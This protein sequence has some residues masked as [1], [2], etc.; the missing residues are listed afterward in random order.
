MKTITLTPQVAANTMHVYGFSTEQVFN[1][2][3][4]SGAF[5]WGTAT[6]LDSATGTSVLPTYAGSNAYLTAQAAP[7]TITL[8]A[9]GDTVGHI[10]FDGT[11]SWTIAGSSLLTLQT[12]PGGVSV[13]STLDGTHTIVAPVSMQNN[14]LKTGTGTLVLANTVTSNG[15]NITI[16]NGTLQFGDGTSHTGSFD[17][18]IVDNTALVFANPGP[19][20]NAGAISGAGTV[21]KTA[22]G[23]LTLAGTSTYTGTTTITGGVLSISADSNLGTAPATATPANIV[24]NGGTLSAS[25][26]MSL[27][28]N[29]GIALGPASGS[30][31]GTI[32]VAAGTLNY[33]GILANNGS[34]SGSLTKNGSGTLVLSVPGT[35]SGT[36][37]ISAGTLQLTALSGQVAQYHFDGTVGP[38][39]S[40]ATIADSSGNSLNGTTSATGLSY[41]AGGQLNQAVSFNGSA[42]ITVPHSSL[43]ALN[44]YTVSAWI[45]L[46]NTLATGVVAGILGTRSGTDNTFDM[47]YENAGGTL[48]IHGDIGNGAGTW[49]STG[50]DYTTTLSLNTWHMITYTVNS[51]GYSIY[52]DGSLGTTGSFSGT[53]LFEGTNSILQIGNTNGTEPMVAGGGIDEVNIFGSALSAAQIQNLYFNGVGELP[54]ATPVSIASGATLDLNGVAQTV[55]SLSDVTG[56]G[57]TVTNSSPTNAAT[58]TLAPT[59]TTTF[60]GVI[61]DGG[62]K[63]NLTINGPGTQI[64]AGANTFSGATTIN[65]GALQVGHAL[66]L[67]NSTVSVNVAGGLTFSAGLSATTLGGLAG[68]GNIALQDATPAAV[69]LSVGNNN[70]STTYSGALSGLGSLTKVGNGTL[71]LTGVNTYAGTTAVTAGT[72]R[73][74]AVS[75]PTALTNQTF[76]SDA[77]ALI[78]T[79]SPYGSSGYTEALAFNQGANLTINGVTFTNTGTATSGTGWSVSGL[80]NNGASGNF[81]AGFTLPS[82]QQTFALLNHFYYGAG[83]PEIVTITG[84]TPGDAYDARLYYREWGSNDSR[85]ANFIFDPGTGSPT[86]LTGLNEDADA[87][88]HYLDYTYIVGSSG[89]LTLTITPQNSA[90]TWHVYGFSNQAISGQQGSLPTTSALTV[91]SGATFDLNGNSQQLAS[92][93]DISGSGGTV[94]SSSGGTPVL[95]LAPT[96]TTTFS[97]VIQDGS[98]GGITS[99]VVNGTGVGTQILAGPNTYSGGTTIT[100]GTLRVANVSGSSATGSGTV[101]VNSGGTL[102]GST[103][104]SQGFVAGAVTLASGGTLA[105]GN[106]SASGAMLTLSAS[107]TSLTLAAGSTLS[108]SLGTPTGS[109]SSTPLINLTG[110]S[111]AL[112]LPSFSGNG[113]TATVNVALSGTP[114]SGVYD[115]INFNTPLALDNFASLKAPTG[116]ANFTYALS[117]ANNGDEI[118]LTVMSTQIFFW[119][120]NNAAG[121]SQWD[122]S[123]TPNWSTTSG[124]TANQTFTAGATVVF[125][126]HAATGTV[127][128]ANAGVSPGSVTFSNTSALAYSINPS[129]APTGYGGGTVGIGGTATVTLSGGG[130][131]TFN[132]QNTYTGST[133][134]TGGSTLIISGANQLGGGSG[135]GNIVLAGGGTL[136]ANGSFTLNANRGITLGSGFSDTGTI[137]VTTGNTLTY[138]GTIADSGGADS[139]TVNSGSGNAGTLVLN[140]PNSGGTANSYSGG[141]TVSSG[142]LQIGDGSAGSGSLGSGSVTIAGGAQLTFDPA[143]NVTF[144]NP[145]GGSGSLTLNSDSNSTLTLTPSGTNNYG[146]ATTIA[147]GTL[148]LGSSSALPV[149]ATVTIGA[150]TNGTFDL[151][152]FNAT[153]SSL[154]TGTNPANQVVTN[155]NDQGSSPTSSTL[156]YAGTGTSNYGGQIT[157]NSFVSTAQVALNITAGTLILSGNNNTFG[158]GTLV[159]GGTLQASNT[160]GSA[161]GT[162]QVTVGNGSANSGTLSGG[163]TLGGTIV[164]GTGNAVTINSGGT[165]VGGTT[166]APL[167]ISGGNGLVLQTGSISSFAPTAAST[168]NPLISVNS[169]TAPTGASTA[170]VS[171]TGSPVAGTYD[172][173]GYGTTGSGFGSANFAFQSTEPAS[174]SLVVQ[175]SQLD[176]VI[177]SGGGGNTPMN[178]INFW[179]ASPPA[180]N[181]QF[182]TAN[183]WSVQTGNGYANIQSTIQSGIAP[184]SGSPNTGGPFLLTDQGTSANP[185][186]GNPLYAAILAGTNTSPSTA[187]VTMSWRARAKQ[188]TDPQDGGTPSSPPLQYVGSYLISNVLNLSGL[189]TTGNSK[190]YTPPG[191]DTNTPYFGS[192]SVTEHQT[193][194]FVLQMNYN[195]PLLSGE[196]GQAKKGTIY[197]GW[198]APAGFG[199]LT[200]PTWE[201]AFTGDFNLTTGAQDGST[202][203]DFIAN[204]QGTFAQFLSFEKSQ[205]SGLFTDDPTLNPA[206]L[207]STDLAAILGSYGVDTTGHDVWA[208]INHNSQFAVVP[209]P[210]T[211]L[212]AALGLAG[213]AVYRRRRRAAREF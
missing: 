28:A 17:G 162:G 163:G 13:L 7:T 186:Q 152:G 37:T 32:G 111:S 211:L 128:I 93:G 143:A 154:T 83:N 122:T 133:T 26:T 51:S 79:T 97:G 56:A 75:A 181:L 1:N 117:Q 194:P 50:A 94:T 60:S 69:N 200:A 91:A 34:G 85:A 138:G 11:N 16:Q 72:L 197:L 203:T 180:N 38:I 119:I 81:P 65:A 101:H 170:L 24:I 108:F 70:A 199:S 44:A 123:V 12:D 100:G 15:N 164:L 55:V 4:V 80:P 110:S 135:A 157:F 202:G 161:T 158:G 88:A 99:L 86:T 42:L 58:L 130:T 74:G 105:A 47:K 67:Q 176:L 113:N 204:Y 33:G 23:T 129:G 184:A 35:Y 190:T 19:E 112:S 29:R 41:I 118:D 201:K 25:G 188:E 136:R 127:Y 52:V 120:G 22:A 31:G 103:A 53:P 27:N 18:N 126:N 124:G 185:N 68:S 10:Q 151:N 87:N 172:L 71:S 140:G 132:T 43:L 141:T 149:G 21:T 3:W 62:S 187:G 76:I 106:G 20:T 102:A 169:L 193:D 84:L 148:Q 36:T 54:T 178:A 59:A 173:I 98:G 63:T 134:I 177:A 189:G 166:T 171:I 168:T 77:A 155:S 61:Q 207:S 8:D 107:N 5:T 182:G 116:P 78:G 139:L 212:L 156:T 150:N 39:A 30:G 89:T 45:D 92:L 153:V 48:K 210:S 183:N 104:A 73:L 208:V 213:L 175:N 206:N 64:L 9:A 90:S 96:T 57:G 146:G 109:Q 198:L 125:D 114:A 142:T 46:P 167:H 2:S 40:G 192:T 179:S 145:I 196:A 121:P 159:T 95:T 14:V 66:A 165:I 147:K 144:T 174:W 131:V 82:N 205:H 160:G 6:W 209:E 49:F 195:V 115:L 191:S 137:N